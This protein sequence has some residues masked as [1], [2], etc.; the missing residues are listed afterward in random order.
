MSMDG[1]SHV[2]TRRKGDKQIL[3][4][5]NIRILEGRIVMD[6]RR[7]EIEISEE[8]STNH[9]RPSLGL[10]AGRAGR[11][12]SVDG[13]AGFLQW[14]G[15]AGL[16]CVAWAGGQARFLP[17]PLPLPPPLITRRR[18]TTRVAPSCSPADAPRPAVTCSPVAPDAPPSCAPR[19]PRAYGGLRR[20][21]H[22][23]P[24]VRRPPT[25]PCSVRPT[26]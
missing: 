17:L 10:P 21:R 18:R 26:S 20:R 9:T 16:S 11:L 23:R 25:R 8:V 22:P 6:V 5:E 24:P 15:P 19:P 14:P 12:P 1:S 2:N 13:L 7:D 4:E 3:L